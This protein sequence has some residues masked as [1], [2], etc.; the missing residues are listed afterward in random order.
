MT[1]HVFNSISGVRCL[2]FLI[3]VLIS[4]DMVQAQETGPGIRVIEPD[5]NVAEAQ[6]AAIDTERFELGLY[7][8]SLS[9]EDFG[10]DIINGMEFSYH[11]TDRW[12]LQANYGI[13]TIDR[14]AFETSQL[15]FLASADRDFKTFS[16]VGGY[17]LLR[18]RSFFGARKKYDSDIYVL[19]G[20]DRISFAANNE[21]GLNFGLSY[22]IVL[23]DWLTMNVDFREHFFKRNFIGDSKQTLNTE[24]RLG[25]N[26]LF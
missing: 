20:P 26:G 7:L 5:Q 11:L 16:L 17:R 24:F 25:I 21:W 23:T 15:Q 2:G 12:L 6:A 8:G 1:K 4:I 9:V 22:R 14:A 13:A 10:S 18:G 19:A 3:A